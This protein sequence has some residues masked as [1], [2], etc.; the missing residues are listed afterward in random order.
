ML[1]GGSCQRD[2][3]GIERPTMKKK[4][5]M[6]NVLAWV[7]LVFILLMVVLFVLSL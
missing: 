1:D 5:R 2:S 6:T 3:T 4:T 7:F